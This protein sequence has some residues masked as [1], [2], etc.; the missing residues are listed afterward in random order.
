[1][2][3][4]LS[5][6]LD[7]EGVWT[8]QYLLEVVQKDWNTVGLRQ[9]INPEFLGSSLVRTF[10]FERRSL[11]IKYFKIQLKTNFYLYEINNYF[12]NSQL[13]YM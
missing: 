4:L 12:E 9:Q 6:G 1:M 5:E 13:L 11:E 10:L 8:V 3:S 7:D 2:I